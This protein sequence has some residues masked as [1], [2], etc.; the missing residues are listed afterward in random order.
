M[1][2]HPNRTDAG[3]ITPREVVSGQIATGDTI[4]DQKVLLGEPPGGLHAQLVM[5]SAVAR[6]VPPRRK[7]AAHWL[8]TPA[9]RRAG[10]IESQIPIT[11]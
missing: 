9:T 5:A 7:S 1:D 2:S 10:S 4:W 11:N 8:P 6:P 3:R